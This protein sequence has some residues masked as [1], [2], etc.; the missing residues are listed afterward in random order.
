VSVVGHP[1]SGTTF[2]GRLLGAHPE[3]AY[4]EEPNFLQFASEL[5]VSLRRLHRHVRTDSV[6]DT[7]TLHTGRTIRRQVELPG[8]ARRHADEEALRQTRSALAVIIGS[9]RTSQST[10]LLQ[11]SPEDVEALDALTVVLPAARAIHVIRDPRD[12][13]A[14]AHR[15]VHQNGWPRWL[16]AGS[17][18]IRSATENWLR[19]VSHGIAVGEKLSHRVLQVRHEDFVEQPAENL[20]EILGL[21]GLSWS[22]RFDEFIE[23]GHGTGLDPKRSGRWRDTLTDAQA[24][25][26]T[27]IAG[28]LMAKLGYDRS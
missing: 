27:T 28:P 20:K 18:P 5:H 15:W 24:D 12:V 11:K 19:L 26:V 25:T 9:A 4:W 21:I 17:D 3:I 23:R 16:P 8:P 6:V 7:L 2:L 10:L 13:A 14:S 1:R 22:S